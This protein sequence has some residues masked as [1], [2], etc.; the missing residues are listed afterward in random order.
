MAVLRAVRCSALQSRRWLCRAKAGGPQGRCV[1]IVALA[2][3]RAVRC[4][5]VA[6]VAVSSK[7]RWSAL[8]RYQDGYTTGKAKTTLKNHWATPDAY[9]QAMIEGLS[10]EKERFASPLNF[11]P[12]MQTYFSLYKEDEVFGATHD[13]FSRPW[14]GASQCNPEYEPNAMDKAVRWAIA[15]AMESPEPTLTAFV[16][17]WWEDTA[18]FKWMTHPNVHKLTRIPARQFRFKRFDYSRTG[19]LHA[20]NPRW[21]V[22]FFVVANDDGL[23]KY[24]KMDI[25]R[26]AMN[27]AA[28]QIGG[29]A[30]RVQDLRRAATTTLGGPVEEVYVPKAFRKLDTADLHAARMWTSAH[31]QPFNLLL[32]AADHLPKK[33]NADKIW[34]TDGSAQEANSG[35]LIGAGVYCKEADIEEGINCSGVGATK[36]IT[37]AELCALLHCLRLMGVDHDEI[38]ATDS[39]ASMQLTSRDIRVPERNLESKH[40]I[41]ISEIA[42]LLLTRA[43]NGAQTSLIKVKSHIGI[44]GN[45]KADELANRAAN[46][47]GKLKSRLPRVDIGNVAF[48]GLFW[49]GTI[50]NSSASENAGLYTVSNLKIALKD[51]SRKYY[52]TGMTNQTMYTDIWDRVTP[53][54]ELEVSNAFWKSHAITTA[55]IRQVLKARYGVMWNMR[56]AYKMNCSYFANGPIA[57]NAL[58]PMCRQTDSTNHLLNGCMHPEMQALQIERHNEAGR[59]ILKEL[60][61]GKHGAYHIMADVGRYSKVKAL[62]IHENRIDKK[63][64]PDAT[65][66]RH[67]LNPRNRNKLRPDIMVINSSKR[68]LKRKRDSEEGR[69]TIGTAYIVEIGYTSEGRYHEKL[70]EKQEQHAQL[71]TLMESQGYQVVINTIILGS[72][73]GI[74]KSTTEALEDLGVDFNRR[75]RLLQRLHIHSVRWL[76]TT[77]KKRRLLENEKYSQRVHRRKKPPDR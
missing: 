31:E 36:T 26:G 58:C 39:Q 48:E 43:R 53:E 23:H 46:A 59:L 28:M 32:R 50:P 10:L 29:R 11:T 17:P 16:L 21:D 25:L 14:V 18:Y 66:R 24:V 2:V 37:R 77:V 34:Y 35:T 64:L 42:S 49:P 4:A 3:S 1:A 33:W 19:V 22:N 61:Q 41:L 65:F 54:M 57:K 15:S 38:I 27:Q 73:G 63:I 9:M 52:Q 12:T 74:F 67:N 45:E 44:I 70:A 75:K 30:C 7:G 60:A 68:P 72:S 76:H 13:A 47:D 71:V 62:G 8:T 51:A 40:R 56:Q 6:A 69:A 20:G 55:A 5:A